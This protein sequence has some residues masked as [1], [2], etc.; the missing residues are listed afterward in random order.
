MKQQKIINCDQ[1]QNQNHVCY[2][3]IMVLVVNHVQSWVTKLPQI[4]IHCLLL[5]FM[6]K[7]ES[8]SYASRVSLNCHLAKQLKLEEIPC[9]QNWIEILLSKATEQNQKLLDIQLFW[10]HLLLCESHCQ[11]Y[12]SSSLSL[13]NPSVWILVP[14]LKSLPVALLLGIA[15]T[16][17]SLTSIVFASCLNTS[18]HWQC[19]YN[20]IEQPI[21]PGLFE[22]LRC[23]GSEDFLQMERAWL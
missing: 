1:M 15:T 2:L 23:L 20:K 10:H 9:T 11:T 13:G 7:L 12:G 18:S 17:H 3:M 22:L 5:G 21:E 8:I 16:D 4:E 6:F 19:S 14:I